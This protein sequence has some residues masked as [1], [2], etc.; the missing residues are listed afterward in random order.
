MSQNVDWATIVETVGGTYPTGDNYNI[1]YKF[2]DGNMLAV[3]KKSVNI[4]YDS[5]GSG[6]IFE[7]ETILPPNYAVPF[8]TTPSCTYSITNTSL[9]AWFGLGSGRSA[10]GGYS[11]S[12]TRGPGVVCFRTSSGGSNT[13][14]V[15]EWQAW[16]RW[17][18]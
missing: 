14:V 13:L 9:E 3:I 17:K 6:N 1:C 18:N 16:G 4:S 11:S 5:W 10:T 7:S 15:I 8:I 12:A 2:A